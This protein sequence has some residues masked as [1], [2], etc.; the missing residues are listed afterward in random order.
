MLSNTGDILF[1]KTYTVLTYTKINIL[2]YVAV[3]V[4]FWPV[5]EEHV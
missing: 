3:P 1:M 4:K 2:K 5:W